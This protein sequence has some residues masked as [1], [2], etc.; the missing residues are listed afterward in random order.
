VPIAIL[1]KV[2][3][4]PSGRMGFDGANCDPWAMMWDC[5]S[6]LTGALWR[7]EWQ[8]KYDEL[9]KARLECDKRHSLL[10]GTAGKLLG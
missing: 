2:E 9:Q 5:C 10:P 7:S 3:A 4:R 1:R 8:I 6:S